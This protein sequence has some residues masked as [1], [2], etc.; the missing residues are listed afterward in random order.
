[1]KTIKLL[2]SDSNTSSCVWK[3]RI[4][5]SSAAIGTPLVQ[6]VVGL[7]SDKH[8]FSIRK[9]FIDRVSGPVLKSLLDRLLEK[10]VINDTEKE[11]ADAKQS[12]HKMASF[13]IDTVRKKGERASSE[14]ITFLCEE[15]QY[16]SETLGLIL[17][18]L[19]FL[20]NQ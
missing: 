1:M 8:L 6:S 16:L 20:F 7:P 4:Y 2:L 14:M 9:A 18:G 5:L 17:T 19:V 12:K 13:V 3:R 11:E 15:D 10:R